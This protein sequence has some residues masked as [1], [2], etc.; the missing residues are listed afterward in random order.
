MH[1]KMRLSKLLKSFS[2]FINSDLR[3]PKL[4]VRAQKYVN[5]ESEPTTA[6]FDFEKISVLIMCTACYGSENEL[7]II[8]FGHFMLMNGHVGLKT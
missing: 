6:T 3:R 1:P 2:K 4:S 5:S 8:F 7:F